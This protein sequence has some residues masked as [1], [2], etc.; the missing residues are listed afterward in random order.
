MKMPLI[1]VLVF[2]ALVVA[3]M[4]AQQPQERCGN[5][6]IALQ[7]N[8]R[9]Q[10]TL[11]IQN[12]SSHNATRHA[13]RLQILHATHTGHLLICFEIGDRPHA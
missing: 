12:A 3:P 13:F 6:H 10:L 7:F 9:L 11:R 5:W 4:R 1:S 2:A 8:H